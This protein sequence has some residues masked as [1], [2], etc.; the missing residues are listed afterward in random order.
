[1]AVKGI[2]FQIAWR[3]DDKNGTPIWNDVQNLDKGL[4]MPPLPKVGDRIEV[5]VNGQQFFADVLQAWLGYQIDGTINV[6]T[7][8]HIWA[9]QT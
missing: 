4:P 7:T 9:K 8:S 2:A 5:N 3:I 6:T 1:M